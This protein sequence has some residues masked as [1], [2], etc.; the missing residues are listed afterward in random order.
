MVENDGS[1]ALN[2]SCLAVTVSFLSHREALILLGTP[3]SSLQSIGVQPKPFSTTA[4]SL[5]EFSQTCGRTVIGRFYE[6]GVLQTGR[7]NA[8]GHQE[9]TVNALTKQF[10]AIS[11][12]SKLLLF[13][14]AEIRS[15]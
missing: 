6:F 11:A 3:S 2:G 1:P 10:S 7:Q 13:Y 14:D 15:R 9:N 12:Q 8:A 5:K 4:N